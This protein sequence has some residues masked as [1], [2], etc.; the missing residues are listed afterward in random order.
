MFSEIIISA[1]FETDDALYTILQI[2]SLDSDIKISYINS[3]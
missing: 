1:L 3:M 2:N